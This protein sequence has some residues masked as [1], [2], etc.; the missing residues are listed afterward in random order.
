VGAAGAGAAR[1]GAGAARV[2][3]GAA[4]GLA[5]PVVGGAAWTGARV[6]GAAVG[7][8]VAGRR[9]GR[10][11]G[12]ARC[13]ATGAAGATDAAG[14]V[15]AVATGATNGV[16]TIGAAWL[17]PNGVASTGPGVAGPGVPG[18][19]GVPSGGSVTR[20]R[21]TASTVRSGVGC[22]MR[23]GVALLL[24]RETPQAVASRPRSA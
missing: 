11:V 23:V 15:L 1:V 5:G 22:G 12:L 17:L 13:G 18:V 20:P 2:G 9:V 8:R 19:P 4:V 24:E 10:S 6:G 3:A 7:A 21:T 16:A 14:A